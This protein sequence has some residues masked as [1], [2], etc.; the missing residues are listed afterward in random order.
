MDLNEEEK[1]VEEIGNMEVEE[2]DR[3]SEQKDE[4]GKE[5]KLCVDTVP[6]SVSRFRKA[7]EE[8]IPLFDEVSSELDQEIKSASEYHA[9]K[10][11]V[12]GLMS[13]GYGALQK[14]HTVVMNGYSYEHA[15]HTSTGGP[16]E[17]AVK[18]EPNY[19]IVQAA[20]KERREIEKMV[21][22]TMDLF[23]K[24]HSIRYHDSLVKPPDKHVLRRVNHELKNDLDDLSANLVIKVHRMLTNLKSATFLPSHE[25][26][27]KRLLLMIDFLE[28]EFGS[29]L[30]RREKRL[31]AL[32][33]E[34]IIPRIQ[35]EA[36]DI[37]DV[38]DPSSGPDDLLA[39]IEEPAKPGLPEP[40]KRG[41]SG[42]VP[43]RKSRVTQKRAFRRY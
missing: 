33:D 11:K 8:A 28:Q 12:Q 19:S 31:R 36:V 30:K 24:V 43:S 9:V 3:K 26:E 32:D 34:P 40:I 5:K 21:A 2:T 20:L 22:D 15:V 14:L 38:K 16:F 23:T 18:I 37:K 10:S 29:V 41:R 35:V 27:R 13:D 4:Q 6:E 1:K 25:S 42:Q 7:I 39:R 17:T